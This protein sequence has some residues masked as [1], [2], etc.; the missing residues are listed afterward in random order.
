MELLSRRS[1]EAGRTA[2]QEYERLLRRWR[3]RIAPPLLV[4]FG[5]SGAFAFLS[6]QYMRHGTFF[7]GVFIGCSLGIA[8]WVWDD[9]PDYIARWK[10]GGDGERR[11]ERQLRTLEPDWKAFHDREAQS[12]NVDHVAVGPAGVFLLDTK[13]L[14]GTI[15]YTP[16]GLGVHFAGT[17]RRDYV[18]DRLEKSL[19]KSALQLSHK[20]KFA[21]GQSK[22]VQPVV[23]IWGDFE[24]AVEGDGVWFVHGS[25]ISDWLRS[26]DPS[27]DLRDQRLIELAI[28]AGFVAP[29]AAPI[30]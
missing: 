4:S 10:R 16:N 14:S 5:L 27:L 28:E 12:G 11:T 29:R 17:A 18:L 20:I 3:F 22:W 7:A 6:W 1:P 30:G 15:T 24:G 23:V 26:R 25:V 19:R 13:T 8:M 9:P 21:T 2:T